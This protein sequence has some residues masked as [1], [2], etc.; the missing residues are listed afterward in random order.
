[1]FSSF[2]IKLLK[3]ILIWIEISIP[4]TLGVGIIIFQYLVGNNTVLYTSAVAW[5][6][7]P[8]S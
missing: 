7:L 5:N 1:M 6:K 3:I 2:G 8:V 4:M